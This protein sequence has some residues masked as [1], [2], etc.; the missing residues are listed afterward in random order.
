MYQP[1]PSS[2]TIQ[3]SAVEGLGL[4]A[5]SDLAKDT[6]LGMSHLELGK[7]I[8]RTPLGG[9][10]NHSNNPNCIKD[11]LLLTRQEW[12]HLINLSDQRYDHNFTKWRLV[13][14]KD[15]KAGEELTL[16]YTWYKPDEK[17]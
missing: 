17:N 3:P 12:N 10:I 13:T 2:L 4:F 15:I 8:L 7:I 11:K 6:D 5:K 14:L 1:L 9:F 16:K